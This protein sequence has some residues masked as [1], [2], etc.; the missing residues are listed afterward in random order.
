MNLQERQMILE[1]GEKVSNTHLVNKNSEADKLIQEHIGSKKDAAYIMTQ[2]ILVQQRA[3]ADLQQKIKKLEFQITNNNE[4]KGFFSGL[5]SGKNSNTPDN[6]S[7]NHAG[8]TEQMVPQNSSI[9]GQTNLGPNLGQPQPSSMGPSMA[10][11][12]PQRSGSSFLGSAMSTAL[13]VAGGMALFNGLEHLFNNHSSDKGD[14]SS[15]TPDA[16]TSDTATP[17]TTTSDTT[18]PNAVTPDTITPDESNS[19]FLA[20]EH[21][22]YLHQQNAVSDEEFSTFRD[23]TDFASET[24][25]YDTVGADMDFGESFDDDNFI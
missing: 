3:L 17:D 13:G 8:T 16:V 20:S 1:L 19:H 12:Q 21:T 7:H 23:T 6:I 18:T 15:V 5:F 9:P 11:S 24:E 14:T 22:D 10:Q 4:K 25:S 2:A